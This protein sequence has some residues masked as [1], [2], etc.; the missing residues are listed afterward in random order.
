MAKKILIIRFS[1][2][3]D[4]AMTVP[5]IASMATQYPECTWYVLSRKNMSGLFELELPNL[6]FVGADFG[7]THAGWRGFFRL[8]QT[9]QKLNPDLVI[10]LHGVIR[11]HIIRFVFTLLQKPVF[12]IRKG[13]KEKKRLTRRYGKVM[14]PLSSTL[15]RY[16]QVFSRAGFT[17]TDNHSVEIPFA[18]SIESEKQTEVRIGVAP[19]AKHAGKIYPKEKMLQL[20][21]LLSEKQHLQVYLFGGG[22]AEVNQMQL[23]SSLLP[24][25]QVYAGRGTLKDELQFMKT[26]Q[27]MISMDSANMHLASLVGVRVVSIWGATHPYAGFS[28][29]KQRNEDAIQTNLACRPCSVYGNKPCFRNDYACLNQIEATHIVERIDAILCE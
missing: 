8:L 9:L 16:Q 5:V 6:H 10:D 1:A 15:E 18:G 20:L 21:Q 2:L 27:L 3:G 23:W 13:R 25:V 29:W 24:N 14:L 4:V 17:F 11:S 26:L 22:P 7:S 19:F 12:T 28:G